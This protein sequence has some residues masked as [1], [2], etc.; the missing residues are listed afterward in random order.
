MQKDNAAQVLYLLVQALNI[1]VTRQSIDD[2]TAKHPNH[3][4]MLALSELLDHWRI[5]NAAYNLTFPALTAAL[6]P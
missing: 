3:T 6:V 4:S 2:E 5:P 1:P